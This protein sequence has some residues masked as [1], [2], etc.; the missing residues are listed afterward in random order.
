[1]VAMILSLLLSAVGG[2]R[3]SLEIA[4]Q[5]GGWIVLSRGSYSEVESHISQEE[6]NILRV[7]REIATDGSGVALISPEVVVPFNAAVLRPATQF[8][9]AYLRGVRP[10]AYR[11]HP[12]AKLVAGQW[13]V[14]GREEM[15]IGQ[16]Q[17][18]RFPELH[19]GRTF[20]YG[21]R[22]WT[23]VGVFTDRGSAVESEFLADLDV[24]QQDARF[25]NAFS[26]LRLRLRPGT[27]ASFKRAL[28]N[29][30][31]LHV[32]TISE[33]DYFAGQAKTSDEL[34][35]LILIVA[36]IVGTGAAFGGMNT[37]Y[38][39]VL[40]RRR[41]VGVLRALGFGRVAILS[42]FLIES[43]ILG[44]GGGFLGEVVAIGVALASHLE[45]RLMSAGVFVFSSRITL[46][47]L[48]AGLV[49][50][51]AIGI[52]GGTLPALSA[53]RVPISDSMREV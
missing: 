14:S 48:A 21:R 43:A 9:P 46:A 2:L 26:S 8:R 32:E 18:A 22:F 13:P 3:A 40:R 50:G 41:E 38:A 49:S 11:V 17:L 30:A 16:K 37:M 33:T 12:R 31:R 42:S 25:E 24:L 28:V 23:I 51:G 5:P 19:L 52:L 39:S 53:S 35:T 27:E 44:L 10:I 34:R 20:R 15:A 6:F 45:S 29:D 1:M 4:G 47:T 36:V 7:R